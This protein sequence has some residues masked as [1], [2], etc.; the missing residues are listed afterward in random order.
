[1]L[2]TLGTALRSG[3]PVVAGN[4]NCF[5]SGLGA[6]LIDRIDHI[7]IAS[8]PRRFWKN[9]PYPFVFIRVHSWFKSCATLCVLR[10]PSL[11]K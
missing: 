11:R 7:E 8:P 5:D 3:P 1:M 6:D 9:T 4:Q 10:K 2:G